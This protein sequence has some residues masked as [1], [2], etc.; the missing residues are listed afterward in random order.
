MELMW[1]PLSKKNETVAIFYKNETLFQCIVLHHHQSGKAQRLQSNFKCQL[2]QGGWR[3][4]DT[5]LVSDPIVNAH[6]QEETH[7][8]DTKPQSLQVWL[9]F[10]TMQLILTWKSVGSPSWSRTQDHPASASQVLG[11]DTCSAM[12]SCSFIVHSKGIKN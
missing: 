4:T 9:S 3:S 7:V 1:D 6:D 5:E 10:L 11:L 2:G 8:S 12:P